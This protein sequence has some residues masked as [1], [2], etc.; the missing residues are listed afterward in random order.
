[1]ARLLGGVLLSRP[2]GGSFQVALVG[3]FLGCLPGPEV[4]HF[5]VIAVGQVLE[6]FVLHFQAIDV[7]GGDLGLLFV[8]NVRPDGGDLGLLLGFQAVRIRCNLGGVF[9]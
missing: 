9:L 5:L 3:G 7:L 8:G 6:F 1:M 2:H 4:A